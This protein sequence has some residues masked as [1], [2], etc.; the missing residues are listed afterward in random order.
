MRTL[1]RS[2]DS[3]AM[4][5]AAAQAKAIAAVNAAASTVRLRFVTD[6]PGQELI[7]SEKRTEAVAF[8]AITPTPV[9]LTAYPFIAG[10]VGITA[11]TAYEVAQL[12]LN[13]AAQWRQAGS[14]LE[15]I[16]LGAVQSIETA[17]AQSQIDAALALMASQLE[18]LT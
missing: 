7:Y 10:E 6:I 2:N 8:V 3:L 14:A 5:L 11:P 16:R 18:A 1:R 9:D 17:T 12:Y 15:T 4:E 13:L